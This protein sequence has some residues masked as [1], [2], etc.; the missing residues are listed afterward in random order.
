[1]SGEMVNWMGASQVCRPVEAVERLLGR[2][3]RQLRGCQASLGRLAVSQAGQQLAL[4]DLVTL[5]DQDLVHLAARL[6]SQVLAAAR[7]QVPF[8][9]DR[10]RRSDR[11]G[12]GRSAGAA[13]AG[14][15]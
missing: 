9:D 13:A 2:S 10:I 8:G 3:Q 4:F 7:D 1:M 6:E 5:L 12:R 14:A 11:G 15:Q